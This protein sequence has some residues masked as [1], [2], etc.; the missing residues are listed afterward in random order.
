MHKEM[1]HFSRDME[2]IQKNKTKIEKIKV[3]N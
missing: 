3:K 1:E 2:T